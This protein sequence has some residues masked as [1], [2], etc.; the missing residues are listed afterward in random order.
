METIGCEHCSAE[1]K[2]ET[3]NDEEVRFCPVCGEALEI[4]INIDEPEHEVD[5]SELWMEEEQVVLIIVYRA[6]R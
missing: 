5:E 6:Q 1:F 3:Y 2:V 4:Y